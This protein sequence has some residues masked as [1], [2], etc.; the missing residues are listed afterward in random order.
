MPGQ[1]CTGI[2]GDRAVKGAE[3]CDDGNTLDGDGCSSIC[4]IEP[5]WDC[6]GSSCVPVTSADGGGSSTA[7]LYCGDGLLSGSEE[8][9]DS[10][11]NSDRLELFE[12]LRAHRC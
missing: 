10:L 6:G 2:C 1:P 12:H 8:C 4:V 11:A 3:T 5:G 7:R 9:D